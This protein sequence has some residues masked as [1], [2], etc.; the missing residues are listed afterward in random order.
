MLAL[1]LNVALT[2]CMKEVE[3]D[4]HLPGDHLA[5]GERH[6]WGGLLE[7]IVNSGQSGAEPQYPIHLRGHP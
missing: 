7:E 2:S 5:E 4:E 1:F 3:S 6:A